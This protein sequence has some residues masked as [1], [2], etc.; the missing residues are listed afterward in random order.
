MKDAIMKG[1]AHAIVRAQA[2]SDAGKKIFSLN[3]KDVTSKKLIKM[4]YKAKDGQILKAIHIILRNRADN[5]G[6]KYDVIKCTD[7]E[8]PYLVF[9]TYYIKGEKR[10]VSF[11]T[12][13]KKVGKFCRKSK[14]RWDHKDSRRNCEELIKY[15]D[16]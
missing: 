13:S 1:L 7:A 3:L 10:Q 8:P 15:F 16:F 4:G 6:V 9:F 2:C 14:V 11:H 5:A 12:Y